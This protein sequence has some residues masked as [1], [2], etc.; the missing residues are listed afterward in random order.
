MTTLNDIKNYAPSLRTDS[1]ELMQIANILGINERSF[2]LLLEA[3]RRKNLTASV[4]KDVYG[5]GTP[6][7]YKDKFFKAL[8]KGSVKSHMNTNW[9]LTPSGKNVLQIIE[10]YLHTPR[11]QDVKQHLSKVIMKMQ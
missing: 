1:W 5:V 7:K 6:S 8:D 2:K 9:T 4:Q 10:T 3:Y 11:H